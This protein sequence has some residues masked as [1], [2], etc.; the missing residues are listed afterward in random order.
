MQDGGDHQYVCFCI[1]YTVCKLMFIKDKGHISVDK[2]QGRTCVPVITRWVVMSSLKWHGQLMTR[3]GSVWLTSLVRG[4]LMRCADGR[5]PGCVWRLVRSARNG[6]SGM[7]GANTWWIACPLPPFVYP[8]PYSFPSPF[9][10]SLSLP[11]PSF[12][13]PH[14]AFANVLCWRRGT[15]LIVQLRCLIDTGR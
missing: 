3:A 8:P 2:W 5:M 1:P 12:Q 9:L 13:T 6:H 11:S 14:Q 7:P 15:E 4:G 10:P